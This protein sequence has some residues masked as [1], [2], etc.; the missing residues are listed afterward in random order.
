M[1]MSE[2][3][4]FMQALERNAHS[5][6]EVMA[7]IPSKNASGNKAIVSLLPNNPFVGPGVAQKSRESGTEYNPARIARYDYEQIT[8]LHKKVA[9]GELE[10]FAINSA[11]NGLYKTNNLSELKKAKDNFFEGI[12]S[13]IRADPSSPVFQEHVNKI[14]EIEHGIVKISTKLHNLISN[15][16]YAAYVDCIL[17]EW[18][19]TR[20]AK[21]LIKGIQ[22]YCKVDVLLTSDAW[23]EDSSKKM[24]MPMC[25]TI[26]KVK[27][28]VKNGVKYESSMIFFI[29]EDG[30]V[31]HE[32]YDY[33]N[34]QFASQTTCQNM[35]EYIESIYKILNMAAEDSAVLRHAANYKNIQSNYDYAKDDDFDKNKTPN[36]IDIMNMI[37]AFNAKYARR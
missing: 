25:I 23:E 14:K 18:D 31:R 17:S 2:I 21:V 4:S 22:E 16:V 26:S 27:H 11:N 30:S 7:E 34:N 6:M 13:S 33:T 1:A 20:T 12:P 35:H 24:Y 29:G 9:W 28:N 3:F 32:L 36:Q 37:D 15:A 10:N 19:I 5:M 8:N